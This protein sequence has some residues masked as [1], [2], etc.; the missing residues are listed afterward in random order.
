M[1]VAGQREGGGVTRCR[2]RDNAELGIEVHFA[3]ATAG[4]RPIAS[5]AAEASS[6]RCT[7]A[8]AL[9]VIAVARL[10]SR[11]GSLSASSAA[12]MFA[13]LST[14]ARRRERRS[15]RGSALDRPVLGHFQAA[16]RGRQLVAATARG[17]TGYSQ[18]HR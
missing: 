4:W 13:A 3:S 16:R 10:F 17:A 9:A 8:S 1:M 15:V 12:A 11:I 2:G 7:Q 5:H 6:A 18:T 14:S